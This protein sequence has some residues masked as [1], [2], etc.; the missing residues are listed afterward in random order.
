MK[1]EKIEFLNHPIF[2]NNQI[3]FMN[4]S[5]D[6][7][8]VVIL[9]GDNGT[10]KTTLLDV[11]YHAFLERDKD[12]NK[13][14]QLKMVNIEGSKVVCENE[15]VKI[16]CLFTVTEL[17]MIKKRKLVLSDIKT[18]SPFLV[19]LPLE[20]RFDMATGINNTFMY[21]PRLAECVNQRFATNIPSL[22]A[23]RI[24]SEIFKDINKPPIETIQKV[25]DEINSIF[26]IMNLE[27]KLTGLSADEKNE[28]VFENKYGKKFNI[29][30]LSSGEKQLF[31][32]ALALKFLNANDCVILIDEPE[33]SLHP[34]WQR[35]IV[36]VYENIGKNNQ[37]I[38]ATHSP[39]VVGGV[40]SESL[41]ILVK[42]DSGVKA[43]HSEE[44][45][46]KV[47]GKRVDDILQLVMNVNSL[48]N[49]D[50]SKKLK[51]AFDL[52][53]ENNYRNKEYLNLIEELNGILGSTDEDLMRLNLE[54]AIRESKNA[55]SN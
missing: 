36:H 23:T 16:H 27:V 52:V 5:G 35:K 30:K 26:E 19:Y 43:L 28:P 13:Y 6:P 38:I 45:E 39:H 2:E 37:V 11:I 20:S 25:C 7:L 22:I 3:D 4:Q 10:G 47:Y 14:R 44:V 51:R 1:I 54:I 32:R 50:I 46:D 8:N 48:R 21:Q 29:D 15:T 55:K 53:S 42:G 31:V 24:Q 17:E 18:N 40:H 12:G 41:R 49:D 34:E 33:L 9:L